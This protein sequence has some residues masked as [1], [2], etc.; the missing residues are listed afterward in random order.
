LGDV[1]DCNPGVK[2]QRPVAMASAAPRT[3]ADNQALT[4]KSAVTAASPDGAGDLR[5]TT[6]RK[7][8]IMRNR[9]TPTLAA[10]AAATVVAFAGN[11]LAEPGHHHGGP[12]QGLDFINVLTALKSDLKL[13]TSQQAMWEAAA[14]QSKSAR[15]TGRANF[16]KVRTAMSAEL[17]KPEP[18]L[19]AVAAVADDAQAAN[20]ALRK[21]IRSQW[22]AL[23]ATFTP[24]QK[25]V[26]KE[27][28][29]KQVARMETFRER[30][31]QRR[32]S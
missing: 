32:G 17:A 13:N 24:D 11:A 4:F 7:G 16:D 3:T 19:V 27:A 23:Y 30:M 5:A 9:I 29:G 18:D 10:V 2:A 21:Q 12:G 15:A 28:L 31:M 6:S 20:T 26:V 22:L 1:T 25:A 14:A 8:N